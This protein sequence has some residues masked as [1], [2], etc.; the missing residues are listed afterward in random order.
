MNSLQKKHIDLIRNNEG[1]YVADG[2]HSQF[3]ST[4]CRPKK[5]DA[6]EPTE[7]DQRSKLLLLQTLR[8]MEMECW[9]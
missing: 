3:G 2:E 4:H 9:N 7:R 6:E 1:C 8:Q 5:K